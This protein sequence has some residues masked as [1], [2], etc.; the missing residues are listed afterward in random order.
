MQLFDC[1]DHYEL[2]VPILDVQLRELVGAATKLY[3]AVM[4]GGDPADAQAQIEGLV[5]TAKFHFA[6]EER[7]MER[8]QFEDFD[9][10]LKQHR[11]FDDMLAEYGEYAA[12]GQT[13]RAKDTVTDIRKWLRDHIS[14]SDKPF[15]ELI[16]EQRAA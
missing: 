2:G 4:E 9:I 16:R 7:M 13:G 11:R 5:A 8:H 12:T 10:H 1:S 6:M 3:Q 15:A 14:R